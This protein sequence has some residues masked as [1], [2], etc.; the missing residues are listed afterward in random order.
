[1][2][3]LFC[4]LLACPVFA[5]TGYQA[6]VFVNEDGKRLPYRLL[7]PPEDVLNDK[8]PLI[9][10]LHG[11]GERGTD[12]QKQLTHGSKL[13]LENQTKYPALVVMPQCP[14]DSYWAAVDID[15]SKQPVG[16]TFR[17]GKPNWPLEA[18]LELV[19]RL[20][21]EY[22]VDKNRIYLVG[23]SMGGMGTLEALYRKPK[24]FAA[25]VPICAASDLD[26][27]RR[28]ANRVPIWLFHGAKDPVVDVKF[29]RELNQRLKEYESEVK[30]T[31]YP[32][33]AHDSWNNAFG[34]PELLPWLF[35][36][37]R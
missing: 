2:K 5:Q 33:V 28:F 34:E 14:T 12:N 36:K 27:A 32:D 19:D 4:L 16:I 23:L 10:F 25:A 21:D 24:Y 35:S 13:F 6:D 22:N 18:A 29:S 11:A 1:M 31:E 3:Y 15:R 17:D 20:V 9:L 37:R 7:L 30:Y 8:P 26:R